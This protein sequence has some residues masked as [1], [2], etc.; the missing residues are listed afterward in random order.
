M[1]RERE[2]EFEHPEQ[3]DHERGDEDR[4]LDDALAAPR[5]I[6]PVLSRLLTAPA[7]SA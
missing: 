7:P 3:D 2:A 1:V 4:E 6:V 5:R